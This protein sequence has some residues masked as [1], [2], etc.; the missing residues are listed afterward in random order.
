MRIEQNIDSVFFSQKSNMKNILMVSRGW[1]QCS[2]ECEQVKHRE[3]CLSATSNPWNLC[4]V[5]WCGAVWCGVV[6]CGVVWCG[7]GQKVNSNH[8][9]GHVPWS[10]VM[11]HVPHWP[12]ELCQWVSSKVQPRWTCLWGRRQ[13]KVFLLVLQV[14][15][16][17]SGLKSHSCKTQRVT[18]KLIIN[19]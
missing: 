10:G 11:A 1:D 19:L 9:L 5:V 13:T 14:W 3:P 15:G 8:H 16:L 18:E 17:C 7:I 2:S 6:R 12:S 4:G